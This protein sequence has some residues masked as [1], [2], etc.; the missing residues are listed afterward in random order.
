M[1]RARDVVP[2]WGTGSTMRTRTPWRVSISARTRPV[3]PAPAMRTC[4][5]RCGDAGESGLVVMGDST[6]DKSLGSREPECEERVRQAPI[7]RA[8]RTGLRRG[9]VDEAAFLECGERAL[10][11]GGCE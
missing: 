11:R 6:S 10:H 5:S 2:G 3:G 8:F 7:R 1:A 4:A 9:V